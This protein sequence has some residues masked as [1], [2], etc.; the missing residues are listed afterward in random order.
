APAPR[1]GSRGPHLLRG[2][3]RLAD[4][5]VDAG[6]AGV[7]AGRRPGDAGRGVVLAWR[8]R[9][10]AAASEPVRPRPSLSAFCSTRARDDRAF[11]MPVTRAFS[12]DAETYRAPGTIGRGAVEDRPLEAA[13]AT[14]PIPAAH[15]SAHGTVVDREVRRRNEDEGG[16]Q[17]E[18]STERQRRR[19]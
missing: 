10:H 8:E 14:V 6:R 13:A 11:A 1:R 9:A 2:R 5:H 4:P 19:L 18:R 17:H 3:A 15:G 7:R 12:D 16:G